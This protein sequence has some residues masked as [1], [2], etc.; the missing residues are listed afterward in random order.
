M[1]CYFNRRVNL[2]NV[3]RERLLGYLHSSALPI[4][5]VRLIDLDVDRTGR[6]ITKGEVLL[7]RRQGE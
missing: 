4:Y 6:S 3:V 7:S 1:V 2:A 5:E